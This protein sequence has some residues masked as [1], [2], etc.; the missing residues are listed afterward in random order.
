[1]SVYNIYHAV[2]SEALKL[3]L[4]GCVNKFLCLYVYLEPSRAHVNTIL[5]PLSC[6]YLQYIKIWN[7]YADLNRM[8]AYHT[9]AHAFDVYGR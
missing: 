8:N 4:K 1:M 7:E 2:D 5:H 3:Y 6:I 9:A